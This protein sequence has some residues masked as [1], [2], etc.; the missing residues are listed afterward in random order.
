M[1]ALIVIFLAQGCDAS[2][3]AEVGS[4]DDLIRHAGIYV[5]DETHSKAVLYG[6]PVY[7]RAIS[8]SGK[9]A[10][11]SVDTYADTHDR[12]GVPVFSPGGLL[13]GSTSIPR[14]CVLPFSSFRKTQALDMAYFA[15]GLDD[16]EKPN[17]G[18]SDP[19]TYTDPAGYLKFMTNGRVELGSYAERKVDDSDTPNHLK[20]YGWVWEHGDFYYAKIDLGDQQYIYLA[21][22]KKGRRIVSVFGGKPVEQT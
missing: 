13:R 4:D 16:E 19:F 2:A 15:F 14:R 5:C 3:P 18:G 21:G 17:W 22:S 11:Y 12:E 7:V 20:H 6:E 1:A 8:G 10:R 9:G